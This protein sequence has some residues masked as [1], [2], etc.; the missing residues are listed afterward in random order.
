MSPGAFKT[1]VDIDLIGS[2]NTLKATLPYLEAS[3]Q[4]YPA[5]GDASKSDICSKSFGAVNLLTKVGFST[6]VRYGRQNHLR[7]RH[8]TLSRHSPA[9]SW[10]LCK[11]WRRYSLINRQHRIWSKRSNIKRYR[12]WSHCK[13]RR[14]AKARPQRQGE[15]G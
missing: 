12:S 10:L 3:A 9:R 8:V 2:F 4:K 6:V 13:Y 1:V 14:H 15:A 7:Q 5:T 11:S